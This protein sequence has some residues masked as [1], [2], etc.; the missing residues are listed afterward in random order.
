MMRERTVARGSRGCTKMK[1]KTNSV[2]VWF[3]SVRFAY[4]PVAISGASWI[5]SWGFS[6]GLL[7]DVMGSALHARADVATGC[8][9]DPSQTGIPDVDGAFRRGVCHEGSG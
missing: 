6:G 1:S 3:T 5:W 7:D 2:S 4:A 9:W 8:G